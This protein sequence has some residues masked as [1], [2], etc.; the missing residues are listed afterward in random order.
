M[1]AYRDQLLTVEESS[2]L[3]PVRNKGPGLLLKRK[4]E[5]MGLSHEQIAQTT[6]IRP[7]ILQALEE[8]NWDALPSSAFV[9]GF[10]RSYARSLG[11][12]E[13]VVSDAYREVGGG[14]ESRPEIERRPVRKKQGKALYILSALL[15]LA[16]LF[17]LFTYGGQIWEQLSKKA[18]ND[19]TKGPSHAPWRSPL[20]PLRVKNRSP[21]LSRQQ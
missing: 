14:T 4:R 20:S 11:L 9:R 12:D 17:F 18:G 3:D 2:P 7:H 10:L 5:E 16:G 15:L 8:E 21:Q 6:K 13:H 1:N 19:L